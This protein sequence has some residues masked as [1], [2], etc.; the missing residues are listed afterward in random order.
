MR[1]SNDTYGNK[2][3]SYAMIGASGA[4]MAVAARQIVGD[5]LAIMMPAKDVMDMANTEFDLAD[6]REGQTKTIKW[7]GKPV[8]VRYRTEEDIEKANNVNMSELKDPQEDSARVRGDPKYLIIVGVCTHLG[9][10]PLDGKGLYG[11]WLCPCHG[12]HYDTSGRIRVGPAPLN[13]EVPEYKFLTD[14]K[15]LIGMND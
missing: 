2:S 1:E 15:I 6:L 4:G 10:V 14:T 11:G 3:F 8:F 13:L 9:C 7:R 12:S 5:L